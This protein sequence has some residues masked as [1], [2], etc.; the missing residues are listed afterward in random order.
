MAVITPK[1]SYGGAAHVDTIAADRIRTYRLDE[2][3]HRDP[4]KY[5][6]LTLVNA[7]GLTD[8]PNNKF[9]WLERDRTRRTVET[10]GTQWQDAE[11]GGVGP[12]PLSNIW[13]DQQV[14]GESGG[15][16]G[17]M[18]M[19]DQLV[20]EVSSQRLMKVTA[21]QRNTDI[22]AGDSGA[23]GTHTKV[24]GYQV[25]TTFQVDK[26]ERVEECLIIGTAKPEASSK[27]G[28][29]HI[30]PTTEYNYVQETRDTWAI[31]KQMLATDVYGN[32]EAQALAQETMGIHKSSLERT[33]WF[34]KR[35]L[36]AG[37]TANASADDGQTWMT[38]GVNERIST[39]TSAAALDEATWDVVGGTNG[40]APLFEDN[41][42]ATLFGFC[43][44]EVMSR[45]SS[46]TFQGTH[47][48]LTNTR[49]MSDEVFGLRVT[50]FVF[51]HGVLKLIPQYEIFRTRP[52]L[53]TPT[54]ERLA[55]M[56]F[57]LDL[58]QIQGCT[59]AGHGLG[60]IEENLQAPGDH[61]RIDGITSDIGLMMKHESK[62]MKFHYTPTA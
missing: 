32:P 48:S 17:A 8:V 5:P 53:A 3:F 20:Y 11:L 4:Y 2:V 55:L 29:T 24:S 23:L 14:A 34:G 45:Y 46:L 52:V 59:L 49:P 21:V 36:F 39:N 33:L 6:L 30:Q 7:I 47:G 1:T 56:M 54:N 10:I 58:D 26:G 15:D 9:E 43:G 40:L 42:G 31:S 61:K 27:P 19:V 13:V 25:N 50:E 12:Y 51:P 57:V 35:A 41:P 28:S 38:G 18:F 44:P 22:G 16:H 37:N 62:H 60:I